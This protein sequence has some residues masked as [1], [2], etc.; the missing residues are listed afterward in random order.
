MEVAISDEKLKALLKEA[1]LEL[2]KEEKTL[3][4][5][6]FFEFFSESIEQIGLAKAMQETKRG[7]YVSKE[8]IMLTLKRKIKDE[9]AV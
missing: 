2:I 5:T 7:E 4:F 3:F 8:E 9:V 6:L 1:I